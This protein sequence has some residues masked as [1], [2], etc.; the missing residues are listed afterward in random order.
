MKRHRIPLFLLLLS[1]APAAATCPSTYNVADTADLVA[2]IACANANTGTTI[3]LENSFSLS[4]ALPALTGI[5]IVNGNGYTLS[6]GGHQIFTVGSGGVSGSASVTIEN[7]VLSG[8]MVTG[9]AGTAGGGGG[10]GAGGAL[11]VD[12]ANVTLSSVTFSGNQATGGT[13]GTGGTGAGANGGF[14]QGG[15]GGTSSAGTAGYGGGNGTITGGGGGGAGFGGAV[16][17]SSNSTLNIANGGIDGTN[18]AT[19]GT[20]NPLNG[21]FAGGGIFLM[22][23]VGV[24]YSVAAGTST[25]ASSIGGQP[26]DLGLTKSGVG[27]LVLSGTNTYTGG[28]TINQGLLQLGSQDALPTGGAVAIATN[29]TLDLNGYTTQYAVGAVT[30][31]G[32]VKLGLATLSALSYADTGAGSVLSTTINGPTSFGRLSTSGGVA[33]NGGELQVVFGGVFSV[34]TATYQII[35]AGAGLTGRFGGV[36]LSSPLF[37]ST[38]TYTSNGLLISFMLAQS[39]ASQAATPNQAATAAALD[40]ARLN[41]N[42]DLQ[43]VIGFLNTLSQSRLQEAFT[44]LSPIAYGA[45]PQ[46]QLMI[47]RGVFPDIDRHL[48]ALRDTEIASPVAFYNDD[49]LAARPGQAPGAGLLAANGDL[50]MK[51][52]VQTDAPAVLDSP[53]GTFAAFHHSNIGVDSYASGAGLQPGLS[54]GIL[55]L[56][57]GA[58]YRYSANLILGVSGSYARTAENFGDGLGDADVNTLLLGTFGTLYEGGLHL[59][60]YG[61]F[62]VSYY[63]LQRAMPLFGSTASADPQG[64]QIDLRTSGGWDVPFGRTTA[65]PTASLEYHYL[66]V[67]GFAENGAGA[68]DLSVG[69]QSENSF[70]SSFGGKVARSFKLFGVTVEPS[71]TGSWRHEFVGQN[72]TIDAALDGGQGPAFAVQSDGVGANAIELSGR[73]DARITRSITAFAE[74][75]GEYGRTHETADQWGFG[76]KYKF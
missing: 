24:G 61:G 71:A 1:A 10:L 76:A 63:S 18:Y 53:W 6:G 69:S 17:V 42:A 56:T 41:S 19:A 62:G 73:V 28:T 15:G 54:A 67:G 66:G 52:A 5:A 58:Q 43:P 27:A 65:G 31:S 9:S 37:A 2:A 72:R 47:S 45:L 20:G 68:E 32:T 7:I 51:E 36:E 30:N 44:E 75:A 60:W 55:E 16:F 25:V 49:L 70:S 29:G 13:G 11:Y 3:S 57:A 50:G 74:Y 12:Q 26:G 40:V 46:A 35:T 33:L 23:G 22:S 4:Q 48:A 64:K 34:S 8:G 38:E 14:G 39:F 21:Q 59:D